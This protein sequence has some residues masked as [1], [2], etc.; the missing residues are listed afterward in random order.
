MEQNYLNLSALIEVRNKCLYWDSEYFLMEKKKPQDNIQTNSLFDLYSDEMDLLISAMF[1]FFGP[2]NLAQLVRL[3]NK[4]KATLHRKLKE[5]V[6]NHV[7]EIKS[8]KKEDEKRV[9]YQLTEKSSRYFENSTPTVSSLKTIY[10]D[11]P[12]EFINKLT[13]ALRSFA[14]LNLAFMSI[15]TENI[16]K[17]PELM[18]E[19]NSTLFNLSV[20][21]IQIRT[22]EERNEVKTILNDFMSRIKKFCLDTSVITKNSHNLYISL[23]PLFKFL[24]VDIQADLEAKQK[25]GNKN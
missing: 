16:K 13:I 18:N 11:A 23:F 8:P 21:D 5:L 22:E 9:Y 19:T 24:P 3:L 20:L 1:A 15:L 6:E 14:S 25:I 7:I 4:P 12:D 10:K 2:L 17:N